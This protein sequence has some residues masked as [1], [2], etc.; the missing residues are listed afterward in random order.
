MTGSWMGYLVMA[1][2]WFWIT[3]LTVVLIRTGLFLATL[4]WMGARQWCDDL[5]LGRP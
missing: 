2:V 5:H 4:L 3:L 1:F